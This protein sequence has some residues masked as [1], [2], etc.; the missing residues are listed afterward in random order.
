MSY[1][2]KL[3][4]WALFVV[5]AGFSIFL[6]IALYG[7]TVMSTATYI[8]ALGLVGLVMGISTGSLKISLQPPENKTKILT[9]TV[10]GV[11]AILLA[12]EFVS[13][14]PTTLA[15][16]FSAQAS[17]IITLEISV[18]EE[19]FFRGFFAPFLANRLGLAK[20]V[21]ADGLLFASYHIVVYGGDPNALI[22]VA[23]SGMVLAFID[24][25]VGSLFP[26]LAAHFI[27]NLA[28]LGII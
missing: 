23:I 19:L 18:S 14:I 13:L 12:N 8:V 6:L 16:N 11:V 9:Y 25:K 24:L 7:P 20:G 28:S 1:Q 21:I 10:I 4:L 27:V 5:T 22:F 26:S 15:I 3:D 2:P 17:Q